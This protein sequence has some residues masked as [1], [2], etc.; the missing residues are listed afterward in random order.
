MTDAPTPERT[1]ELPS[2]TEV[3]VYANG[4]LVIRNSVVRRVVVEAE[5]VAD[6]HDLLAEVE[7]EAPEA[8]AST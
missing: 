3:E 6:L 5:D 8:D 4:G 1:V 2:G 7:A